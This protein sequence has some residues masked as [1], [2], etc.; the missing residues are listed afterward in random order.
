MV[1]L[2]RELAMTRL[3]TLTGAGGSGKTR[4]ALE[5]ARDLAGAYPDGVWFVELAPLSD[6]DLVPQAVAGAS[7][8]REQPG[9]SLVDTLADALRGRRM[10]LILDNCEHLVDAA[11]RLVDKLLACCPGLRILA[12]SREA[13]GVA[14][15][16]NRAVPPLSLPDLKRPL[17][18]EELEGYES[19]RLFVERALH[20]P[21]AFVLTPQSA[22][23]VAEICRQLD[24]I[25]LAIELAAA[26]VGA[27]AVEQISERLK[28]SLKLLTGGARTAVARQQTLR[29]SLDWGYELLAQPERL[30]FRR[31]SVFAGGFSLEAAEAVG[32]GYGVEEE[33][34]LDL[35]SRLVDKSLVVGASE[36][37]TL[38]YGMLEPVRQYAREKLEESGEAEEVRNRHAAFF[39]ALA[40]EAEPQLKSW[41]QEEWLGRL[42][43]ESDNLRAAL[44]WCADAGD[45][46]TG[47]RLAGA[48]WLYWFMRGRFHE[49]RDLTEAMLAR[50]AQASM[51]TRARAV[52]AAAAQTWVLGDYERF[53]NLSEQSLAMSEE[54]GDVWGGA[55]ALHHLSIYARSRGDRSRAVSL[56][57][58]GLARARRSGDTW[59]TGTALMT[60]G[61]ALVENDDYEA[62]TQAFDEANG[63]A[64]ERGDAFILAYGLLN[65]A[66][67]ARGRND[68]RLAE[69][70]AREGL[71][72]AQR[73]GERRLIARALELLAEVA[74]SKGDAARAARLLGA[75]AALVEAMGEQRQEAERTIMDSLPVNLRGALGDA[76]FDA[77][78]EAGRVMPLKQAIEYALGAEE[79]ASAPQPEQVAFAEEREDLTRREREV[80]ALIARGLTNRQI[81][82]ELTISERT[83]GNHVANILK[84]LGLRSRTQVA[85]WT[86]TAGPR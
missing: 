4:L 41:R 76:A 86:D 81:S 85:G 78:W 71:E 75:S 20:R 62:A 38:R 59:L 82:T 18:V 33:D 63:L 74:W 17:T 57:E 77:A 28:D 46:E 19:A 43:R 84:K 32:G 37:G 66:W 7:G 25:P 1:G 12:T 35:V 83:V 50:S 29:G 30:L 11:A 36:G 45:A 16:V 2:K 55:L 14:G 13:L 10:L 80:A 79:P 48:L 21:S 31:V 34:I 9:R 27:L 69:A 24:G 52:A 60:L 8:V 23:A 65:L 51:P 39:L 73:F 49:G 15:E 53:A 58:E 54:L 5:V 3:L 26:R 44:R 6:P 72:V 61:T 56:A 64:R 40:E 42:D 47:T 22:K 68:H 67:V 70:T